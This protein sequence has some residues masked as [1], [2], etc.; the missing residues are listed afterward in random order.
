MKQN[1]LQTNFLYRTWDGF[2]HVIRFRFRMDRTVDGDALRCAVQES[3]ARYPYFCFRVERQGESYRFFHN[4]APIPVFRGE[5]PVCLGSE[6]A[7]GYYLAAAYQDETILFYVYHNLCDSRGFIPWVKTVLYLYLTKTADP[8]LDRTGVNLPGEP[9]LPNET[10]DPYA[11]LEIPEDLEPFFSLE[12]VPVF[13]P[14]ARYAEGPGRMDYFVRADSRQFMSLSKER[15]GSPVVLT[16]WFLKET[17]KRLFPDRNGLPIAAAIPHSLRGGLLGENNYHDQLSPL[18]LRYDERME[19][20]S[21]DRQLT[22]SRGSLFLQSSWENMLCSIRWN[23]AFSRELESMPTVEARRAASRN[24][25]AQFVKNP[26]TMCVTYPGNVQ[27]GSL[28]RYV[29]EMYIHTTVLSAPLMVVLHPMNGSF[30]FTFHQRDRSPLFADT[31]VAL[32]NEHGIAAETR[33]PCAPEN[34]RVYIP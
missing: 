34:C 28:S 11:A 9:F 10:E 25:V 14:D 24:S 19:K 2:P 12:P 3:A 6:E 7:N 8:A 5:E 30:F 29:R 22:A 1:L 16:S 23:I 26:E 18:M 31:F 15:D 27:W 32:L 4:D 33:G 21:M 17:I 13:V 20:L